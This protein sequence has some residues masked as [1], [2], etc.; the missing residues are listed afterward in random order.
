MLKKYKIY[1]IIASVCLITFT[2]LGMIAGRVLLNEQT[3]KN[4]A[5][6]TEVLELVEKNYVEPVDLRKLYR[7]ALNGLME[8][9][10]PECTYLTPEE[11]QTLLSSPEEEPGDIGVEINKK[12]GFD[13]ARIIR[14]LPN[15]PAE[16]KGLQPGDWLRA[17]ERLST[18]KLS[19]WSIRRKLRGPIDSSVTLSITKKEKREVEKVT[20]KRE[21]VSPEGVSYRVFDGEIGYLRIPNF[22]PGVSGSVAQ[23]LKS[24]QEGDIASLLID[25]R[26]DIRGELDEVITTADMLLDKGEITSLKM[27][28]GIERSYP[29][30]EGTTLY[31]GKLFMLVDGNTCNWG[32]ILAAAIKDNKRGELIG[33]KTFGRGSLQEII[34]LEDGS[35]LRLSVGMFLTPEKAPIEGKGVTPDLSLTKGKI[36]K[37]AERKFVPDDPQLN[38]VLS[39]IAAGQ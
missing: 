1:F 33:E 22:L 10:D 21:K 19:L 15:S 27:L 30:E 6:L 11:Y 16:R 32:E 29:A 7:G 14:V 24:L 17:V 13:Y 5:I 12:S 8:S 4:L 37:I 39:Y 36:K 28:K 3:Y 34:P 9:L 25:L 38:K 35:A 20:L 18:Q 23:R 26:A 2:L 31:R